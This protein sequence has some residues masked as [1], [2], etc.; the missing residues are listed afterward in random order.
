MVTLP[1]AVGAR[2][3]A[4]PTWLLSSVIVLV[5]LLFLIATGVSGTTA[6]SVTAVVV[7]QSYSGAR[8]W[9]YLRVSVNAIEV[10]GMGMAIGT[11]ACFT[12][13]L[14]SLI[15]GLGTWGWI[16]PVV[17]VASCDVVFA[18]RRRTAVDKRASLA[19][20][21]SRPEFFALI[22]GGALAL[23]SLATGVGNYP[24]NWIGGSFHTDMPFFEA[25]SNSMARLGPFDSI[26]MPGAEVKYHWFTYGWAGQVSTAT[27]AESFVTLTRALPFVAVVAASLIVI[28]W[29]RRMSTVAWVPGLAVL[30]LIAGGFL[31]AIYGGVLNFDS[32][33]Q[34]LGIVW[35]LAAV[36]GSLTLL[37]GHGSSEATRA[38]VLGL[39]A[40]SGLLAFC[41]MGAKVSSSL[42]FVAGVLLVAVA[43]LVKGS[44]WRKPAL[45]LALI[46][47]LASGLAFVTFIAGA[48]G[49]GGL[50]FGNLLDKSSS[51]QGLNPIEG[52]AGI[53]LGTL[54]LLLAIACRWAGVLWLAG[55]HR[56]RWEPATVM[57][58]G[59]AVT[60][61]GA[62]IIFN[63]FNELWFAT[64]ASAPLSVLTAV[65]AGQAAYSAARSSSLNQ[66]TLVIVSILAAGLVYLIVWLLWAS[67]ASGGNVW[68]STVRWL[69]PIAGI[70]LV[71]ALGW[72]MSK[73]ALPGRRL[74]VIAAT[75]VVMLVFAT[76]FG[77]F[78]GTG[79]GEIGTLPGISDDLFSVSLDKGE[80]TLDV[81][82]TQ[83]LTPALAQGVS[84][85]GE[86]ADQDHLLA[87]NLTN[88]PFI[89]AVT[90]LQTLVSGIHYQGPYGI[91]GSIPLLLKN[92]RLSWNFIDRPSAASIEPL[93]VAGVR[94]I[95]V[96]PTLAKATDWHPWASV[97]LKND[98]VV[99]LEVDEAG[100]SPQ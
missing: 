54:I 38:R 92:E 42:P 25:L 97:V 45:R 34:S 18:V 23:G 90:G 95:W 89:A 80:G 98:E 32:P 51:Q 63:G 86:H 96:D 11:A 84:W 40:L 28:A 41:L 85:L 14:V 66:R 48:S 2:V 39:Y 81:K 76:S 57:G 6:L 13:G 47:V 35:L 29:A 7:L 16:L 20:A 36:I 78:L 61:L 3:S 46:V 74:V 56:H 69:G 55:S 26:F 8:I 19:T 83:S 73:S 12:S 44:H 70:L 62:V 5:A 87:T 91:G 93:C 49:A 37:E 65:G 58:M 33:S 10:V 60:S 68:V 88:G 75:S 17:V 30:T 27:N 77:R 79:T 82:I 15:C 52:T 100:C 67:G 22:L 21:I 31:G 99:L 94:W 71:L 1:N 50:E 9:R 53:V 64:G 43:A 72:A 59:L 4:R 24:L